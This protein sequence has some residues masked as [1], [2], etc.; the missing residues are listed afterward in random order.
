MKK[1]DIRIE[2]NINLGALLVAFIGLLTLIYIIFGAQIKAY[3][4]GLRKPP[5]KIVGQDGANMVLI[6]RWRIPDGQ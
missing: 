5:A 1:Q 2:K 6:P 3:V 4:T